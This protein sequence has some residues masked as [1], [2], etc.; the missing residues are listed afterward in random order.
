MIELIKCSVGLVY[1]QNSIMSEKNE[2]VFLKRD[3]FPYKD[4]Y[5][6]PGGKLD[7]SYKSESNIIMSGKTEL[8]FE[9]HFEL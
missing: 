7:I 6:L 3:K 8:S 1:N 5:E 2:L 9:G 4:V